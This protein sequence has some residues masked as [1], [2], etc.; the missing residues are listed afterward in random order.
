MQNVIICE[1]LSFKYKNTE[2]L[3]DINF[4]VEQGGIVGLLG[5]NGAGKSTIIN[6][7]MGYLQ[8][9]LGKCFVLGHPSFS[10][11]PSTR[12]KIGLVHEG[13]TQYDFMSIDEIERYYS[14][15]YQEWRK[16]IY[17][18]LID[19][20][21]VPHSRKISKLSCGQ[22]SQVTLGLVLAQNP[23]LLI[24]DD[25]SMGLDVGYR[26]LF[27]EF[28]R[29]FVDTYKTTV[30]LTSHVIS[31]LDTFLD[32]IIILKEGVVVSKGRKDDFTNNFYSYS[33]PISLS[34]LLKPDENIV[35]IEHGKKELLVFS[36]SDEA[37]MKEHFL[38]LGIER[39]L[40]ENLTQKTMNLEDAFIGLTGRYD[41]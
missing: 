28:L 6:I 33:L 35:N 1:N 11:P 29:D 9:N 12:A 18:D 14:A 37:L 22:R 7:L 25:F 36:F 23:K 40:V 31:E 27:L 38:K 3:H 19:R 15:Y 20:M 32:E 26:R 30:L 10:I 41:G 24:L 13:F 17:Y 5:K 16:D 2:V 39:G 21:K 34:N 4:E 8:P